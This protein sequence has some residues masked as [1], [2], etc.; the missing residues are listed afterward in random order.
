MIARIR[1]QLVIALVAALTVFVVLGSFAV[2]SAA[3]TQAL[4]GT[5]YVEGVVGEVRQLNPLAQG[6]DASQAERDI[7]ALLFDGLTRLDNAGR[8]QPAL[9]ERWTVSDD[10]RT[11]TFTLRPDARWHDGAPVTTDD[12][13]YTVRGVQNAR[14]PGDPAIASLWRNV[15]I[16]RVD[17]RTVQ[18]ELPAPFAPFPSVARLPILPAH[19]LRTLRP[20]QWAGAPFSR[21]PIG[22]G[23]FQLRALDVEQVLLTP[24]DPTLEPNNLV[25]RLYPT[26]DA[27]LLALSRQEVQGVATPAI[28]GRRLPEPSRRS[29][30]TSLPLGEYTLLAFNM[31]QP[32][33]DDLQFRR[34]LALGLNRDLL[35]ANVLGGQGQR[36]DTPILPGTWANDPGAK[37]PA[38]RRSAAQ[39]TLGQ[40]GYVDR[41]GDGTLEQNGQRLVLPLL[42]ADTPEQTA[43]AAEIVRQLRGIGVGINVRR[44]APF[45]LQTQLAARNFTLA[46]HSWS[47]VGADPD[48][49]ALWH[50]SQGASGANY[51][52]LSDPTVDQLLAEARAT[53]DEAARKRLY[54][55]F[56]RRWVALVPSL[57]LYGGVVAY[58][59][60]RVVEQPPVQATPFTLTRADRWS[61]LDRWTFGAQ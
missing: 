22:T 17:D 51:A 29:Q 31:Q 16:T 12:V 14:F 35:I 45:E 7:A 18:F 53:T 24:T 54:A 58:N 43:L 32:P 3:Q 38:F 46:L 56:Q 2:S 15:L 28:A 19:L 11:Y 37:L 27:A 4:R 10:G 59:V 20:E 55:E 23:R 9:A 61:V 60:D 26:S 1:W 47:N 52:G 5:I 49:Y 42:I 8:V 34:A 21:Q 41:N 40:L 36:L 48:V 39:Q 57:P 50:S 25:L 13:L 44:V 30:R 6:E 33:L